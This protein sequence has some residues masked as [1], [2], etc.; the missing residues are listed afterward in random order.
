MSYFDRQEIVVGD[1]VQLRSGGAGMTV[2][3]IH[4][5]VAE[6]VWQ[7]RTGAIRRE[8]F[9]LHILRKGPMPSV[10]IMN[11]VDLPV[12]ESARAD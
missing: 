4:E 5:T 6:C 10:I 11:G 8:R 9:S 3:V 2:D 7:L 12:P 1:V